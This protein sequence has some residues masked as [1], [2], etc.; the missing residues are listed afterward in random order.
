MLCATIW[1]ASAGQPWR[2]AMQASLRIAARQCAT[3]LDC[4][5]L[6]SLP[7]LHVVEDGSHVLLDLSWDEA[8]QSSSLTCVLHSMMTLPSA[9]TM[10]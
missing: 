1:R 2:I 7:D 5:H 8:L 9:A 10:R 3:T 6:L 4:W